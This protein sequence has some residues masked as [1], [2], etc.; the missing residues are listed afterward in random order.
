MDAKARHLV[1]EGVCD[2]ER[3]EEHLNAD[4]V[5]LQP[6]RDFLVRPI[7]SKQKS[8]NESVV[9][10][11]WSTNSK[12]NAGPRTSYESW[13]RFICCAMPIITDCHHVKNTINFTHKNLLTG[14]HGLSSSLRKKHHT[15]RQT[16]SFFL[17]IAACMHTGTRGVQA[18]T[19]WL[20]RT[21][22]AHRSPTAVN[23]CSQ[24]SPT[25]S[26]S[27]SRS[28]SPRTGRGSPAR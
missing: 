7:L 11:M 15:T 4:E 25:C 26:P 21:T 5:V 9:N 13:M 10:F 27:S 23:S 2:R 16:V 17:V 22:R 1:C 8:N 19:Q 12:A 3:C 14:R 6:F 20:G 18:L 28:G 24:S